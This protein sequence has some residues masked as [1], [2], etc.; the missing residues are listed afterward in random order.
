MPSKMPDIPIE[1]LLFAG[2]VLT[3]TGMMAAWSLAIVMKW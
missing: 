2:F 3:L 1:F